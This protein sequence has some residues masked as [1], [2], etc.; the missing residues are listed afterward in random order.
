[1]A[2][3]TAA[4]DSAA[5]TSSIAAATNPAVTD[6]EDREGW[7][8]VRRRG[9]QKLDAPSNPWSNPKTTTSLFK[10]N[11]SQ[12][13]R[14]WSDLFDK[15]VSIKEDVIFHQPAK[16][17]TGDF[18][19]IDDLDYK[20]SNEMWNNSIFIY[21][22][23]KRPYYVHFNAYIKRIWKPEGSWEIFSRDNGFFLV[24]FENHADFD[25]VLNGGPWFMD[26][27]LIFMKKWDANFQFERDMLDSY[28]IWVRLNNLHLS[29]WNARG[30]SKLASLIGKP[31]DIDDF[32]R[33][34][35]RLKF[36]RVL[37]EVTAD[38]TFPKIIRAKDNKGRIYEQEVEYEFIP[39]RC[40][41]CSYFGHSDLQ[42][43]NTTTQKWIPKVSAPN[44]TASTN[45]LTEQTSKL[46]EHPSSSVPKNSLDHNN[47]KDLQQTNYE[48]GFNTGSSTPEER[49]SNLEGQH[50][51]T[52]QNKNPP[53]QNLVQINE[54]PLSEHSLQNKADQGNP[55]MVET[56]VEIHSPGRSATAELELSIAMSP[57]RSAT[58]CQ[59]N[60]YLANAEAHH[61]KSPA[62]VAVVQHDDTP[63]NIQEI[64]QM[65]IE[66]D[67]ESINSE[68]EVYFS[69][70]YTKE[71]PTY[72]EQFN[73]KNKEKKKS[74]NTLARV[75]RSQSRHS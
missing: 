40:K 32:T 33:N 66:L 5:A 36:A 35:K 42:C 25:K 57:T 73:D 49:Q 19:I 51:L 43:P 37:I 61:N 39:P 69:D 13:V 18:A 9:K 62:T 48:A 68:E 60:K 1:M 11:K 4:A 16:D 6:D 59:H 21:L 46:P 65:G 3:A 44:H 8:E 17:D 38:A 74:R 30:I 63:N 58:A 15:H 12:G 41:Q 47:Y 56:P 31:L 72:V 14:S 20:L 23:G 2:S 45:T 34:V 75:T 64:N 70:Q 22:T 50:C 29:L 55:C 7:Q 53:L 71:N 28:P 26:S 10:F 27:R 52:E 54:S 24:K 67:V